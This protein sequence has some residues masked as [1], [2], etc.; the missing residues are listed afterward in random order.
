MEG[1]YGVTPFGKHAL[2]R[3][4]TTVVPK[5]GRAER[6]AFQMHIALSRHRKV[7]EHVEYG[8]SFVTSW[9]G[10]EGGV[11]VALDITHDLESQLQEHIRKGDFSDVGI[12]RLKAL[13]IEFP[14]MP[15]LAVHVHDGIRGMW[16]CIHNGSSYTVVC[17]YDLELHRSNA[18]HHQLE[19]GEWVLLAL[20]GFRENATWQ[21]TVPTSDEVAAYQRQDYYEHMPAIARSVED[22]NII[23]GAATNVTYS[24][25][26]NYMGSNTLLYMSPEVTSVPRDDP[27]LLEHVPFLRAKVVASMSAGGY[28]HTSLRG[29]A[30]RS[31][32]RRN[33]WGET[34]WTGGVIGW[35]QSSTS[36]PTY[37]SPTE[38][39]VGVRALLVLGGYNDV[40]QVSKF[41][42]DI[43]SEGYKVVCESNTVTY[44]KAIKVD[45]T[46]RDLILCKNRGVRYHI[47]TGNPTFLN[48]QNLETPTSST[49]ML[50]EEAEQAII[51]ILSRGST[52]L[53][54]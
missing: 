22:Q 16:H 25:E 24:T 5:I 52:S 35:R 12:N 21:E 28:W 27:S 38:R 53:D 40:D 34:V 8:G 46:Y 48:L 49:E 26:V 30:F 33:F 39:A 45:K 10:L 54:W 31:Y 23:S 2:I 20:Q 13:A 44:S 18:I 47:G 17:D 1:Q 42:P 11:I 14:S 43:Y 6:E 7:T 50:P 29:V 41:N 4:G 3:S 51:R 37:Y 36:I 19:T 15:V 32:L 9:T